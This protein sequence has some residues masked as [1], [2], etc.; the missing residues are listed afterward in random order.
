LLLACRRF[1]LWQGDEKKLEKSFATSA[2][3]AEP[4][5]AGC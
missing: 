4:R 2:P 3:Q 1:Q 5:K